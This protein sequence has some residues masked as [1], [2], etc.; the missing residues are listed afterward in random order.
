MKKFFFI[1]GVL[2][3]GGFASASNSSDFDFSDFN[4][5]GLLSIQ[6]SRSGSSWSPVTVTPTYN[7]SGGAKVLRLTDLT[8]DLVNGGSEAG[9]AWFG[10]L[11]NVAPGFHT[12]VK[13]RGFDGQGSGQFGA[14]GDGFAIGIQSTSSTLLGNGGDNNGMNTPNT[15]SVDF[16]SFWNA[17]DLRT[18]DPAANGGAG[19]QIVVATVANINIR[20]DVPHVY[21][22]NY[23]GTLHLWDVYDNG[24]NVMSQVYDP[25]S[26]LG[27]GPSY[28][29]LGAGTGA[30]VDHND[31]LAWKFQQTPEPCSMIAMAGLGLG[32][33]LK[34][35]NR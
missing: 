6:G 26:V 34:R 16:R 2:G 31:I 1:A 15:V 25:T 14:G 35:R 18:W 33:F 24:V 29:G 8:Y 27:S 23:N 32:I 30:D 7:Y 17:I 12:R 22:V 3:L 19:G 10:V 20:G 11:E 13:Y 5:T 4:S 28:V 21:D 9:T